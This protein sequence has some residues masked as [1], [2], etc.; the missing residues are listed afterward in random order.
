ML[1]LAGTAIFQFPSYK[2]RWFFGLMWLFFVVLVGALISPKTQLLPYDLLV[3]EYHILGVVE[4][5][6]TTKH[7][8]IRLVILVKS[9]IP[10][11]SVWNDKRITVIVSESD[12]SRSVGKLIGFESTIY[13]IFPLNNPGSFDYNNYL[14]EQGIYGNSNIANIRVVD[15]KTRY[16]PYYKLFASTVN[17][18]LKDSLRQMGFKGNELGVLL[19]M[20]DGDRELLT[21]EIKKS[22]QQ[23]GTI[24]ILAVSGLHVGII[25]E[26]LLFMFGWLDRFKLKILKSVIILIL[27]WLYA[28][29]ANLEPS[30]VRATLMFSV[31]LVS[32]EFG[33]SA[34]L[35]NSLFLSAFIILLIMPNSLHNAGFWL[36]YLAVG[37]IFLFSERVGVYFSSEN[38]V[39]NKI[40]QLVS[41]TLAAQIATMPYIFYLFGTFSTYFLL[42]NLLILP[43]VPLIMLGGIGLSILSLVITPSSIIVKGVNSIVFYMNW[44]VDQIQK[45]PYSQIDVGKLSFV[46]MM[47]WYLLLALFLLWLSSRKAIYIFSFQISTILLLLMMTLRTFVHQSTNQLVVFANSDMVIASKNGNKMEFILSKEVKKSGYLLEPYRKLWSQNNLKIDTLEL[48]G[49]VQC[50]C[51]GKTFGV[52]TDNEGLI[53]QVNTWRFKPQFIYITNKNKLMVFEDS[54][55]G[56]TL[57]P[58]E[59]TNWPLMRRGALIY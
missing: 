1:L 49:G 26:M 4:N 13:P 17:G 48:N 30:I 39:L 10:N 29:V 47:M 37:S 34:R 18:W 41:V 59:Y 56:S 28:I 46:E 43:I 40:G 32:R 7:G 5:Q 2:Y 24:H 54:Y 16:L 14:I 11:D 38:I 15:D 52:V 44:V 25:V 53:N 42:S 45:L 6:V 22:Y 55:S 12:S 50:I 21:P 19:A 23:T 58:S 27:V 8:D 9:T 36:S 33:R 35:E 31:L 3:K 57:S 20:L 51:S